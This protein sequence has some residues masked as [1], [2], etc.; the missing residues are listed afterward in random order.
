MTSHRAT[1]DELLDTAGRS[2]GIQ[3]L[4]DRCGPVIVAAQ[5]LLKAG[6][7]EAA[8]DLIEWSAQAMGPDEET[9]PTETIVEPAAYQFSIPPAG[10]FL[11]SPDGCLFEVVLVGDTTNVV[12]RELG[13]GLD[14]ADSSLIVDETYSWPYIFASYR[15][16]VVVP[17]DPE[18]AA[19][20]GPIGQRW[21]NPKIPCGYPDC[22]LGTGHIGKHK[23][24][25]GIFVEIPDAKPGIMSTADLQCT[26]GHPRDHGI[27]CPRNPRHRWYFEVH[28]N[29][30]ACQAPGCPVHRPRT[31]WDVDWYRSNH[32]FVG[33]ER[34]IA[35][36]ESAHNLAII[37][38]SEFGIAIL[39]RAGHPIATAYTYKTG[40]VEGDPTTLCEC[41][42]WTDEHP[43]C[44]VHGTTADT[45]PPF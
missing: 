6:R 45:P 40:V 31:G 8:N 18:Q 22:V 33:G 13:P 2:G 15:R 37:K 35:S 10:I 16:L 20:Y 34:S 27:E 32:E 21:G 38:S 42:R 43:L 5:A 25:N 41:Q 19:L 14:T 26:C 4:L 39:V 7:A 36:P 3:A 30:V 1:F 24:P 29:D 44:P 17:E 11:E 28:V 9:K 12:L 23:L